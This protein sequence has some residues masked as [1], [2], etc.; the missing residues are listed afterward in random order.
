MVANVLPIDVVSFCQRMIAVTDEDVG[1]A[2]QLGKGW[3]VSA[4]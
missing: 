2:K 1:I 4:G 3:P